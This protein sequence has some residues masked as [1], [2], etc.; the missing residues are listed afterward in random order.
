M[1]KVLIIT[2]G[3][4]PTNSAGMHRILRFGRWLPKY[5]WLPI[6]LT[7]KYS[8]YHRQ[9]NENIVYVERYFSYVFRKSGWIEKSLSSHAKKTNRN[10]LSLLI[11]KTF[12]N[13]LIPDKTITWLPSAVKYGENITD[14]MSIDV[15]WSS[16]GPATCG[17]IGSKL[18][19]KTGIPLLL[20]YRDPWMLIDY[21]KMGL[22]KRKINNTLERHMI[23]VASNVMVTSE[24]MRELFISHKFVEKSKIHVI[25]NGYDEELQQIENNNESIDI[26]KSKINITHT[27]SFYG[28]RQPYSFIK[29][30]K[31]LVNEYSEYR[32]KIKINF[33]GY[34]DLN[35]NIKK[36]CEDEGIGGM[37]NHEGIVAYKKAMKYLMESD[38][39]YLLNGESEINNIY[40][41]AKIFDYIAVKKPILFIGKGQ[42]VD[43]IN[44]LRIGET[45]THEPERIKISL[46]KL[47]NNINDYLID[48]S[49][50][51]LYSSEYIAG[52]LANILDR[53]K[54]SGQ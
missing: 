40:I 5:G 11:R 45:T 31:L 36:Y 18:T 13:Q 19:K 24:P 26:D 34:T 9:D 27:G 3:F 48:N 16:I 20:D 53:T 25:T 44:K 15:I 37:F 7:P 21:H 50:R 42:P 46:L 32:D 51:L 49:T 14:N 1:K 12:L 41:P 33:I 39:L 38:I 23:S 6:I 4:P 35:D 10:I 47:L 30:I 22:L 28:D 2:Y 8:Y 29:A 54:V 52:Q 43:I 17:L